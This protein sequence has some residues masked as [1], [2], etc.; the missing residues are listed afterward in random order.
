MNKKIDMKKDTLFK[1]FI[2]IIFSLLLRVWFLDKPEGLYFDEYYSWMIATK[3]NFHDFLYALLQNC[4]TPLYYIYLKLWMFLFSDSDISLRFSSVIPSVIS[5]YIMYLLGREFKDRNLGILCALLT[6]CSSFCIYF[7]QE[8]RLYSILFLFSSLAFYYFIKC[9]KNPKN[10]NFLLFFVANA[11]ICAFHTLGIIFSFFLILILFIYLYKYSDTDFK[12]KISLYKLLKYISPLILVIIILLP[13]FYNILLSKNLSQFWSDFSIVKIPCVFIDYFSP[14]QTNITNTFGSFQNYTSINGKFNYSFIIFAIIPLLIAI[15]SIGRAIISKNKILNCML[16]A[17][18]LFFAVILVFAIIG[19]LILITKYTTEIYPILI[20]A[21]SFGFVSFRSKFIRIALIVLFLF[22]N[23]FYLFYSNDSA[24]K[25][26]RP[27]GHRAVIELLKNS[28]LRAGD[29]VLLTYYDID[30][31]QKYMDESIKFN[32][33]SINKYNFN[34]F[35]FNGENYNN[36]IENGKTLHKDYFTQYPNNS[37]SNY[38]K[39]NFIYKMK[40]GNR[41]GIIVLDSVSFITDN[42]MN[43]ILN[44]DY[45]YNK[46]PFIFLIFSSLKNSA[47]YT[48]KKNLKLDTITHAGYWTLY[49]YEKV[50]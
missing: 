27:E 28:R 50:D 10:K 8:V 42:E 49:V 5:V 46:I 9:A 25:L 24:A 12:A 18:A 45:K 22:L 36:I 43:E 13:F 6:A 1:L 34:Y 15:L 21:L 30:K 11:F 35:L 16:T 19:K 14:I 4:H 3:N 39:Y 33:Y 41:L 20:L 40:K 17:S 29:Y 7:A 32:F 23:I 47:I 2:I 48:C 38:I 37:V 26:T 31:F 44:N